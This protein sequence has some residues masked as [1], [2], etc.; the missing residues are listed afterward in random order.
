MGS[1][2]GFP[3]WGNMQLIQG[4]SGVQAGGPTGVPGLDILIVAGGQ[5]MEWG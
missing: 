3:R 5:C 1:R 2:N 4:G